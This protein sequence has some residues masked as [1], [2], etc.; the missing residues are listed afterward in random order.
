MNGIHEVR[1][2]IPLGS[3]NAMN[4]LGR[5]P[6]DALSRLV[7]LSRANRI[8]K[9]KMNYF[10]YKCGNSDCWLPLALEGCGLY[11]GFSDSLSPTKEERHPIA[12][13]EPET[14]FQ[15]L[16]GRDDANIGWLSHRNNRRLFL[17]VTFSQSNLIFGRFRESCG[18][19]DLAGKYLSGRAS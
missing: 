6:L 11:V 1:G 4:N 9:H 2:S 14:R 7:C 13:R 19:I 17:L 15:A 10:F 16:T 8:R 12:A 5:Q 18:C 3:T